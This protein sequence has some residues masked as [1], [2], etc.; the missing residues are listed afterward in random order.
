MREHCGAFKTIT[1]QVFFYYYYFILGLKPASYASVIS[2]LS[3]QWNNSDTKITIEEL[4]ERR[5]H[6][7]RKM[8]LTSEFISHG[9][10]RKFT[11]L[12]ATAERVN[13]FLIYRTDINGFANMPIFDTDKEKKMSYF[14]LF[15][16][17]QI[18]K[19]NFHTRKKVSIVKTE[20]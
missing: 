6:R 3:R 10:K 8:I 16:S 17:K 11:K 1:H 2:T 12:V 5:W 15:F 13:L 14:K 18:Y 19:W 9:T 20:L 4:K 7:D